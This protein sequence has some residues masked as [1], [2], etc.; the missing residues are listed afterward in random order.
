MGQEEDW[1]TGLEK[2]GSRSWI[3]STTQIFVSLNSSC[4]LEE[5][6]KKKR[7][8]W[9]RLER[10]E[11]ADVWGLLSPCSCTEGMFEKLYTLITMWCF[12]F[13]TFPNSFSFF[14]IILI[15]KRLKRCLCTLMI[16]MC[17]NKGRVFFVVF[18]HILSCNNLYKSLPAL[19]LN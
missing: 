2:G 14:I 13:Q 17:F 11:E 16:E 10:W 19:G 9:R 6:N 4:G 3:N 1:R 18:V 12:F 7:T 5:N 8:I 15:C